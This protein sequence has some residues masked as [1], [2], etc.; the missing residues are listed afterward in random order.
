[1]EDLELLYQM[2]LQQANS[3]AWPHWYEGSEFRAV[4]ERSAAERTR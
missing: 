2:G 4:R 3:A 1:M